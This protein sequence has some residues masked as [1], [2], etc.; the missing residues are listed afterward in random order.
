MSTSD[1][2]AVVSA[3]ANFSRNSIFAYCISLKSFHFKECVDM[4]LIGAPESLN[5]TQALDR[6]DKFRS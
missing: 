4:T 5:A 2:D 3:A 1:S 6:S